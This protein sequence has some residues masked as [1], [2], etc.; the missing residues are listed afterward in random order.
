MTTKTILILSKYICKPQLKN[1]PSVHYR[2]Q[3]MAKKIS[4]LPWGRTGHG[5]DRC[6]WSPGCPSPPRSSR[7]ICE[8]SD[9]AGPSLTE[10]S[11]YSLC[12]CILQREEEREKLHSDGINNRCTKCISDRLILQSKQQYSSIRPEAPE[13]S[14][15]DK[16]AT[17]QTDNLTSN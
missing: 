3:W 6:W 14:K 11:V 4:H 7:N 10:C 16:G 15:T 17:A 13:A 12:R 1:Q 5:C 2:K 8:G 9:T